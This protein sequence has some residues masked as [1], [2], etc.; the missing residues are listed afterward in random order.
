MTPRAKKPIVQHDHRRA[1]AKHIESLGHRHNRWDVFSDFVEMSAISIS[2]GVDL[3]QREAREERYLQIVKRYTGDELARFP[4]MFGE[5]VNAL[6]DGFDDV[7]GRL[8]HDLELHNKYQGQFFSPY[9]LCRMMA[10]VT[11]EGV[12]EKVAAQGFVT[13]QEP[14]C[15]SGAMVIAAA[16]AMLAAGLNYQQSMHA[17]LVDVDP[18]CV[19]MAYVQLSLLHVPAI[20]VLGNTL[21]LEVRSQWFTPAHIMGGWTWRLRRAQPASVVEVPPATEPAQLDLLEGAA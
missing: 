7:L 13:L 10:E 1:I 14:A 6:E 11:L 5:L 8:F 18:K 15:G 20:V 3:A 9:P 17:T 16:D 21:S 12:G 2:N 4:E 19:H